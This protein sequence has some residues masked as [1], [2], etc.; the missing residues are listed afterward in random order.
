M[1]LGRN[2]FNAQTDPISAPFFFQ[3]N[4]NDYYDFSFGLRC[5]FAESGVVSANVIVPLNRER[6]AGR[7]HP[8]IGGRI[9]VQCAVEHLT[10]AVRAGSELRSL[11]G[12]PPQTG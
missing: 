7:L 5:L 11:A 12:R 1:F 4:R 9:R 10:G 3:I 2:E 8:D 6:P